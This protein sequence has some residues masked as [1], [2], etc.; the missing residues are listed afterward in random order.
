[1]SD[2]APR[3]DVPNPAPEPLRLVQQFVNT[4]DLS[5]EREWLTTWLH[6]QGV[7]APTSAQLD[8][9]RAVRE[10]IRELVLTDNGQAE[11]AKSLAVLDEAAARAGLTI[12]FA[13]EQLVVQASGLDGALGRVL[14][15]CF[16]SM[17]S[18][19]WSRLKC[20]RNHACR[21]AFYD[22]SKNRSA[23]WCSMQICGNRKKT[24]EYR[25]RLR[26]SSQRPG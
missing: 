15:A 1:M 21:W 20:C 18:G 6:E 14:V 22:Q 9:A 17:A 4:I 13:Q 24:R 7:V 2:K 26:Q 12:D 5:H 8:R 19:T 3:Y 11:R 23:T 10:A 16:A 25:R